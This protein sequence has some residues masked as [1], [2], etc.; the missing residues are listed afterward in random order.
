[1]GRERL[2][3][4]RVFWSNREKEA[5][6]KKATQI[7][8]ERPDLSG[9]PLLR[10]AIQS[11]PEGRRRKILSLNQVPWFDEGIRGQVRGVDPSTVINVAQTDVVRVINEPNEDDPYLPFFREIVEELRNIKDLLSDRA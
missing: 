5:I 2:P 3:N 11:L 9:L 8:R 6:I 7:Q 1:M 4:A 10:S